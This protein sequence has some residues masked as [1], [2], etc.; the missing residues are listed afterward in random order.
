MSLVL[1][2]HL[3]RIISGF[4]SIVVEMVLY[5]HFQQRQLDKDKKKD[6]DKKT[7]WLHTALPG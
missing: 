3:N 5:L 4:G 7:K 1:Y 2:S 6:K